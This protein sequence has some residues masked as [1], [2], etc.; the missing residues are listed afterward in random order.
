MAHILLSETDEWTLVHDD[1]DLRGHDLLDANG[2][3]IGQIADMV[4]DTQAKKVDEVVLNDGKRFP[5]DDLDIEDEVVYLRGSGSMVVRTPYAGT[6]VASGTGIA[7]GSGTTAARRDDDVDDIP[8]PVVDSID[9]PVAPSHT[10]SGTDAGAVSGLGSS[11]DAVTR[12][13]VSY[14]RTLPRDDHDD[15]FESH[16]RDT[17]APSGND[18]DFYRPA[19]RFGHDLQDDNSFL[20]TSFDDVEPTVRDRFAKSFPGLRYDTLADAIRY[21]FERRRH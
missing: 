12:D 7:V 1:Q 3:R 17:Y 8:T 20:G 5:A 18:F 14:C 2:L 6:A 13:Y 10:I 9:E 19:Y 16:Y 4:V 21:G 11:T 15:Y